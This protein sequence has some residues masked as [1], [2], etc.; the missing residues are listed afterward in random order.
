VGGREERERIKSNVNR[1][2]QQAW[3]LVKSCGSKTLCQSSD[4]DV[5]NK[6]GDKDTV[7]KVS[8]RV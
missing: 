5:M 8:I 2:K 3:C 6:E 1:Q 7:F 4:K